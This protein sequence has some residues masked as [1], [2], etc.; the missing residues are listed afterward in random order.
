MQQ[1]SRLDYLRMKYFELNFDGLVGP[2]HNYAGLSFGNIASTSHQ[3]FN[4]NPKAAA[5]EGLQKMKF[6]HELGI[7]QAII[8]PQLRPDIKALRNFYE[9]WGDDCM[10]LSDDE[11]IAYTYHS[12]P[13]YL[14]KV[15]SASSMWTANAATVSPSL[16]SESQK[17]QFTIANLSK[18][19]HR[20]I[21]ASQTLNIFNKIFADKEHFQI[22]PAL[23]EELSDEGAANHCRLGSHQ[24]KALEI[25]VYGF[26][27]P[28]AL[29]TE[30]PARQSLAA[31]EQIAKQHE[32]DP[33]YTV[34]AEQNP[35]AID[36]GV[37][38]N[39]VISAANENVFLFHEFSFSEQ[40]K[41]LSEIK[42]KYQSKKDLVLIE[43]KN[44]ELDLAAAVSSYLFNSQLISQGDEM[45]LLCPEEAKENSDS[46]AV[47]DRILKEDN[48]I[49]RVEFFNLRESMR[50]GGGPAC[51]R[52]RVLLSETELDAIN[53]SY[54]FSEKLYEEL[55][56]FIEETY[57]ET[58]SPEDLSQAGFAQRALSTQRAISLIFKS[59]I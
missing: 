37:F 44:S 8:P 48:P 50:N 17:V 29:R 2:T 16:D 47:I 38:H 33:N 30:F 24:E 27:D 4:S 55:Q 20:S 23:N 3:G 6:L 53:Q 25:F 12:R 28:Q 34:F 36:A 35:K 56:D 10:D 18:E 31:S 32:L 58:L 11:M 51:L 57:P 22:H 1:K 7:K 9:S 26:K 41:V 45:I 42:E 54:L 52:L 14:A 39:D 49:S 15:Y 43:V 59:N 13:E 40:E 19:L 21:E 46:K 5:L